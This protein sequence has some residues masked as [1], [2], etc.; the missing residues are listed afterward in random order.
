MQNLFQ[1]TVTLIGF[2]ALMQTQALAAEKAAPAADAATSTESL[3]SS[4]PA[5]AIAPKI[6]LNS[7]SLKGD[8]NATSAKG[9]YGLGAMAYMP[10]LDTLD[11]ELGA[12]YLQAGGKADLF[13]FGGQ[14][15]LE[16]L[17]I[18]LGARWHAFNY[19]S[20][21]KSFFSVRGGIA[22]AYLMSA[23]TTVGGS[24]TDIKD[25]TNSWNYLGYLGLGMTCALANQQELLFE[26]NYMTGLNKTFKDG[27]AKNEGYAFGFA[28]SLPL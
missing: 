21:G 4:R 19:G 10:I 1:K 25:Q 14:T 27:N 8:G 18:P 22:P 23:K 26:L 9:G 15:D 3:A 20:E 5:F 12:E 13:G 7:F 24:S 2:V 17:S 11:F 6:E 28:Y 16:Y